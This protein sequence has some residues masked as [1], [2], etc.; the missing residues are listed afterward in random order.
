M[1]LKFILST[2]L[3]RRQ[4]DP[5]TLLSF[6]N[7]LESFLTNIWK[8]KVNLMAHLKNLNCYE[9]PCLLGWINGG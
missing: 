7:K 9:L 6:L 3:C 1:A 4:S 2:F 5:L 8:V